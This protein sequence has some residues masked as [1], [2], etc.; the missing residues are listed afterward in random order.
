MSGGRVQQSDSCREEAV[1]VPGGLSPV[2]VRFFFFTCFIFKLIN[3]HFIVYSRINF[4]VPSTKLSVY[5]Y[6]CRKHGFKNN[7]GGCSGSTF[8]LR[9]AL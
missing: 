4:A 1:L 2:L 7:G 8:H 5:F 6:L 3:L 9:D